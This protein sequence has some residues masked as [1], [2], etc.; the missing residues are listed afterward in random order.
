[1]ERL[2][3]KLKGSREDTH[4]EFGDEKPFHIDGEYLSIK[5]N[6][7]RLSGSALSDVGKTKS[8][9]RGGPVLSPPR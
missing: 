1:M 3:A 5:V 6:K 8:E 7:I 9:K 2:A 4:L